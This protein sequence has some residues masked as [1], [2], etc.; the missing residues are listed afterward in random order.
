MWLKRKTNE[1]IAQLIFAGVMIFFF[2][3]TVSMGDQGVNVEETLSNMQQI[4]DKIASTMQIWSEQGGF[5]TKMFAKLFEY[6]PK[7]LKIKLLNNQ[8]NDCKERLAYAKNQEKFY[9]IRLEKL[10]F[11]LKSVER[12]QRYDYGTYL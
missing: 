10:E 8:I 7:S 5:L 12:E 6:L 1:M 3:S 2:A 9:E 4:I 11:K